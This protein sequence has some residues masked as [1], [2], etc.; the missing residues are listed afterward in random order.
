MNTGSIRTLWLLRHA[1]SDWDTGE[2]DHQR[3]LNDRGRADA[4]A[5]GQLLA[6]RGWHPEL[7]LCSSAVRTRQTWQRALEGGATADAVQIEPRIYGASVEEL[8]GV[9]QPVDPAVHRL[10]LIGHGP[11][12]PDLADQLGRRPEPAETW[13]RMDAKYP[14][15]GLAVLEFDVPWA[16]VGLTGGQGD[17]RE[18]EVPRG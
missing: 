8:L 16:E 1:K 6:D 11:G 15:A 14:T 9:I 12:I 7:V 13:Q 3:P 4:Y 18:F 17:L 10:M 2:P 5:A